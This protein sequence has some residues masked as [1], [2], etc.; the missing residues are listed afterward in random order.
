MINRNKVDLWKEDIE[1]SVDLYNT[2]F[3]EFVPKAYRNT[4][5]DETKKVKESLQKLNDMKNIT[6]FFLMQEPAIVQVLRMCTAPP[7]ASDRLLGLS[8]LSMTA[9]GFVKTLE[10]GKLPKITQRSKISLNEGL[11][12][13]SKTIS[14][15][16][17]KG[18]FTW[19]DEGR[20]P[21]ERE[22]YRAS[23]II[24]DRLCGSVANPIIRNAQENRQLKKIGEYLENKGYILSTAKSFTEMKPGSYSFRINVP[25]QQANGKSVNIPVDTVIKRKSSNKKDMPILIECKSAGDFANTNKRRK[26]ESDKFSNLRNAYG[27]NVEFL[28]FLCGYFDAS[29]LGYGAA[30]GIDWVWEHRIQDLDKLKL[31]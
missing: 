18:V 13:I 26:E 24:A 6:P 22:R 29:Y 2:W 3:M 9:P 25:G 7:I 15:M 5:V 10:K 16:L 12:A 27:E 17:D 8:G 19:V 23:T 1:K 31:D 11:E 14:K 21:N 28:L 20:T 30:E 4:R